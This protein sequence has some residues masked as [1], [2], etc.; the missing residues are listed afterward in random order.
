MAT[1]T[2]PR[3]PAEFSDSLDL[4]LFRET[5]DQIPADMR[6]TCPIHLNWRDRCAHLHEVAS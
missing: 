6:S 3:M 1:P 4:K 5:R 2:V